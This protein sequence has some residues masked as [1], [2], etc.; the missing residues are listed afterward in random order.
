VTQ[1]TEDALTF[2]FPGGWTASKADDWS[3]Y[4]N[5]FERYFDGIRLACKKCNAEVRCHKCKTA[6]TIG[7]KAVDI[8]A[9][10][11]KPVAWLIEI[12]DYRQHRRTKAIDLADEVAVKVRDSLAMFSAASKNANQP[13]EKTAAAAVGSSSAIRVVL[14][15]EQVQKPSKLFP[16]AINPA[17]VQ[18]RLRR[19]IRFVDPHPL[20]VEKNAMGGAAWA[21]T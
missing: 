16:R 9:I 12:K 11:S 5:Q 19:L 6:K 13:S 20:V 2:T 8:L 17:N 18:Q 10:D 14:H 15:L 3:F 21:V 1:I 4:R 7:A